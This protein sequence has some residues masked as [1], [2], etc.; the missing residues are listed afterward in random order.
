[1]TVD[2]ALIRVLAR[3]LGSRTVRRATVYLAPDLVVTAAAHGKPHRRQRST[4][5]VVTVG[6]PNFRER[7]FIKL[8]RK[9]GV[10]FPIRKPQ[11]RF[12]SKTPR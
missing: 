2:R 12:W 4:S 5:V 11:L 10:R 3:V 6:K 1:M 8:C 9:A 7:Q